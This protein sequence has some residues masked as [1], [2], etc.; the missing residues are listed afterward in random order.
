MFDNIVLDQPSLQKLEVSITA[1][2]NKGDMRIMLMFFDKGVFTEN[3]GGQFISFQDLSLK[4]QD[5]QMGLLGN[6]STLY[7]YKNNF[8]FSTFPQYQD[9]HYGFELPPMFE[10]DKITFKISLYDMEGFSRGSSSIQTTFKGLDNFILPLLLFPHDSDNEIYMNYSYSI[11]EIMI[12]NKPKTQSITDNLFTPYQIDV[13]VDN[14]AKSIYV[15]AISFNYVRRKVVAGCY[16]DDTQYS[17]KLDLKVQFD[18]GGFQEDMLE[19]N[20]KH[21]SLKNTI[22][23]NVIRVSQFLVVAKRMEYNYCSLEFN[24]ES[25]LVATF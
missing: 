17:P 1:Q 23:S 6:K 12:I 19:F 8:H 9:E 5:L 13:Y 22:Y 4:I 18:R 25:Q 21:D 2:C 16:L 24:D 11:V 7:F 14:K 15:E 10:T 3:N 20:F